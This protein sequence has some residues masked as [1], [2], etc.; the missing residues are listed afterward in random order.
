M[1]YQNGLE[2]DYKPSHATVPLKLAG[3][4]IYVFQ[5]QPYLA[6]LAHLAY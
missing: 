5:T 4:E 2:W 6:Y 1:T 3:I